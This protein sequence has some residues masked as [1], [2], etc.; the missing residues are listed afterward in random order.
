MEI[1]VKMKNVIID[2]AKP[3][4]LTAMPAEKAVALLRK[5]Y[6]F[7]AANTTF[8]IRDKMVFITVEYERREDEATARDCFERGDIRQPADERLHGHR[9]A[10]DMD[11]HRGR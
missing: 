5:T 7:L 4:D 9:Q 2:P 11:H 3:V 1:V 6:G 8:E 10:E